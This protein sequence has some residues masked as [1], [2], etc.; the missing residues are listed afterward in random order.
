MRVIYLHHA[1]KGIKVL[2]YRC[3]Q[4]HLPQAEV[5]FQEA[6]ARLKDPEM[7]MDTLYGPL[8]NCL[9]DRHYSNGLWDSPIFWWGEI[10]YH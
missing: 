2:L 8:K 9:V 7:E 4:L 10:P 6:S 1:Y 3:F 5:D